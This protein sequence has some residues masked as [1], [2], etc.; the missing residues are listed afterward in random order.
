MSVT[1]FYNNI[2]LAIV[3][4]CTLFAVVG[5]I[6]M[7]TSGIPLDMLA[8]NLENWAADV[9]VRLA[10]VVLAAA[11]VHYLTGKK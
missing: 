10:I 1:K 8:R 11:G 9:G 3:I 5:L 7:F 4:V 6:N 2:S